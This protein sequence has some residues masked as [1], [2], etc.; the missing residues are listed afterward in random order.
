MTFLDVICDVKKLVGLELH[1]IRPGANIT[2]L[3]VDEERDCLIL[4]TSQGRERSRPLSEL[5]TIWAEL[6]RAPAVHVDLVLHG[7]G[8]SR[9]QPETIFAN[10]P[11]IEWV[12]INNKK[13]IALIEKNS[14]AYGTLRQMSAF[15]AANLEQSMRNSNP[16]VASELIIVTN[17]I[18]ATTSRLSA[19]LPGNISA[20]ENGIYKFDGV[21]VS[22][23]IVIKSKVDLMAG[24]YII[25]PS[26]RV[27]A[28]R[29]VVLCNK[30]Y[31]VIS[32]MGDIKLLMIKQ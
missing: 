26:S 14:H 9:N 8:T 19:C 22:A 21:S 5:R 30:E 20:I 15:E 16:S 6:N 17:D 31:A 13:H 11:Y 29:S 24:C 1:S 25:I 4:R 12:K 3:E 27:T 28:E 23:L 10:L 32:E 18:F 2:I 7:S